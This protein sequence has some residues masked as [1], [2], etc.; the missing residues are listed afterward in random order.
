MLKRYLLFLG[1]LFVPVVLCGLRRPVAFWM[2]PVA[3]LGAWWAASPVTYPRWIV[4]GLARAL[5]LAGVE[6]LALWWFGR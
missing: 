6:S 4:Q 1:L 2:S 3:A 5:P